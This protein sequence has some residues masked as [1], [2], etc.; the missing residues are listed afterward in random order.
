MQ[1]VR[2]WI[3]A[4]TLLVVPAIGCNEKSSGSGNAPADRPKP[5]LKDSAVKDAP[6]PNSMMKK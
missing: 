1:L 2:R 3:V 6:D 5:E 4:L